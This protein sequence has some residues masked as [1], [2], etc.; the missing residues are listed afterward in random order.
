[1]TIKVKI[2]KLVYGGSGIG[3]HE[4]KVVF[5]P[6]TVP[7]DHVEAE[8]RHQKKNFMVAEMKRILEPGPGRGTPPCRYFGNCGG[9][10]WQQLEY[11]KQVAIKRQI[12]EDALRHRFPEA[13][14]LL[15]GIKASP[16]EYGYRSRARIQVRRRGRKSV[17][18]FFRHQSHS[19]QDINAC[20]LFRPT[21]NLALSTLRGWEAEDL[22]E[23]RS[24]EIDLTCAE[25]GEEWKWAPVSDRFPTTTPK[26]QTI[27]E[28]SIRRSV[29]EFQ[30]LVSPSVFFQ[31]ND[32]MIHELVGIVCKLCDTSEKKHALDLFAGVGLFSL[33]LSRRFERITAVD[34]SPLASAFCAQNAASVKAGNI[35]T[36]ST[37]VH[38]WL[39]EFH[40]GH[41]TVDLAVINPPRRGVGEGVMQLLGKCGPEIIVYVACDPNTLIRDLSCLTPAYRIE[42]VQGLDLFPQTFH[43]ETVVGLRRG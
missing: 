17:F 24:R 32:F 39:R 33:P 3:R 34:N 28:Q 42:F 2:T 16:M 9:C 1:M 29:S 40:A 26:S 15:I 20:P 18:G 21:L 41:G 5:V 35:E 11:P 25:E 22:I 4:G 36:A 13:K 8:I 27:R 31:A 30:Y 12:L 19:V 23:L 6:F 10:Q 38:T 14:S 37:D 43:F 7:G